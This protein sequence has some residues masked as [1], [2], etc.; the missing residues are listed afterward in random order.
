MVNLMTHYNI[1]RYYL[2]RSL[3]SAA[4]I[5]IDFSFILFSSL[6]FLFILLS[7]YPSIQIA[8]MAS[9]IR[10]ARD[11]ESTVQENHHQVSSN[12]D[13]E[14]LSRSDPELRKLMDEL[15]NDLKKPMKGNHINIAPKKLAL[16][17]GEDEDEDA[18]GQ[19]GDDE[20]GEDE[21]WDEENEENLESDDLSDKQ[22]ANKK[23]LIAQLGGQAGD[24][25]EEGEAEYE[26]WLKKNSVVDV[27]D[28]T[29]PLATD[30]DVSIF[31]A[32]DRE[33]LAMT[34]RDQEGNIVTGAEGVTGSDGQTRRFITADGLED[35]MKE[36]GFD[37]NQIELEERKA[38]RLHIRADS[39]RKLTEAAMRS[40]HN[41]LESLDN[42]ELKAEKYKRV[43]Y[44][45]SAPSSSFEDPFQ[46]NFSSKEN[47]TLEGIELQG[48]RKDIVNLLDNEDDA[49]GDEFDRKV[50]APGSNSSLY[51]SYGDK[52]RQSYDDD[53]ISPYNSKKDKIKLFSDFTPEDIAHEWDMVEFGRCVVRCNV[54]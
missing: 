6:L 25:Y 30:A 53:N 36:I 28:D 27:A 15:E 44:G 19:E 20:D 1:I 9:S 39:N 33:F 3:R 12:V 13:F 48:R 7:S 29:L 40:A 23:R 26:E 4:A 46:D 42:K 51:D 37:E 11:G 18:E 32:E 5:Q 17:A 54:V 10:A 41:S 49:I 2:Y 8:V 38:R 35:L 52:K 16:G 34:E 31:S 14:E 24:G 22:R 47:E 50:R 45:V 21:G 43:P